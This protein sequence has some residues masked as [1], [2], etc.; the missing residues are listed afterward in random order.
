M[1][2]GSII[3][4]T[5]IVGVI[6]SY[7]ANRGLPFVPAYEVQVDVPDAAELVAGGSEVRIGGARAG[8]VEQVQAHRAGGERPAY[9]R[10]TLKLE[11]RL[12]PLPIDSRVQVR[13]RSILG[14]KFLDLVVGRSS[15]G[16]AP[17]GRLPLRQ[18]TPVV[19]LDEAF[20]VF[21]PA[22]TKGLQDTIVGLGDGLAG[23]GSAINEATL[24]GRR[25]LGPGG[26]V[27]RTLA[28]RR[29]DLPGLLDGA[30]RATQALSPVAPRLDSMVARGAQTLRAVELA[31]DELERTL[32]RLPPAEVTATRALGRLAP[33]LGDAAALS[34]ELRPAGRVL[35]PRARTIASAL[36]T[37][38]PVLRRTPE[39]S[40]PLGGTLRALDRLSRD[41]SAAGAV[42]KLIDTLETLAPTLATFNPAQV[43][44][45]VA[46]RWARNLA[47]VFSDGDGAGAWLNSYV[48]V[49][50]SQ[51]LQSARQSANL[52]ANPYPVQDDTQCEAGNEPYEPGR[53]VGNPG[54]VQRGTELTAPPAGVGG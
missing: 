51:I 31:G 19:E 10:L 2:V 23:R 47:S 9:A 11:K 18:A 33:V 53:R 54:G 21:D 36:R 30:A 32:L 46:G 22:T 1:L 35:A 38:T 15:R 37:T 3:V 26:R 4:L 6:V 29:T 24:S 34:R 40:R 52:H 12:E 8:L 44:C 27:L 7:N 28:A 16:V 50:P 14:S 49:E 45:N 48:I 5:A 13:P 20:D 41:P 42:R 25:L 39:L 17:G 43:R